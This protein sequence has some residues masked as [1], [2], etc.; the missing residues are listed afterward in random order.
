MF[1]IGDKISLDDL[2]VVT[3]KQGTVTLETK[4]GFRFEVPFG[5]IPRDPPKAPFISALLRV[6]RY[7]QRA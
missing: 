5:D 1:S 6:R 4:S 3:V 2:T 7:R